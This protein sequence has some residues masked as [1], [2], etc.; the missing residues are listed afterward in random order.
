ME[1]EYAFIQKLKDSKF[2]SRQYKVPLTQLYRALPQNQTDQPYLEWDSY[3]SSSESED[4]NACL[5]NHDTDKQPL[6]SSASEDEEKMQRKKKLISLHLPMITVN[7][8][9]EDLTASEEGLRIPMTML[10]KL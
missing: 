6:A 1:D 2:L 7:R 9:F 4:Y 8:L 5:Q 10:N 3:H